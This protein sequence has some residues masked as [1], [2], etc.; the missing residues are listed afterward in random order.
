[1]PVFQIIKNGND[2]FAVQAEDVDGT[3][4]RISDWFVFK[5]L[6]ENHAQE[7]CEKLQNLERENQIVVV[8]TFSGSTE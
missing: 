3:W 5:S 8:D 6:A 4:Y 1:M 7:I 2:R